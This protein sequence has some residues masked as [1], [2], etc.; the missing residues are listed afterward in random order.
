MGWTHAWGSVAIA[1]CIGAGCGGPPAPKTAISDKTPEE[2]IDHGPTTMEAEIGGMNEDA[3]DKAF[4]SLKI[5]DCVARGAERVNELGGQVKLKLRIDREGGV[6][7]AYLAESTL[8]DRDTEKCVI[9]LARART[10]PK[11]LGGE[12]LAEKVYAVDA[13]KAPAELDA[14]NVGGAVAR[15]RTDVQKCRGKVRGAFV[16]TVYVGR[17]GSVASAGVAV[18]SEDG[19]AVADC[20]V[21]ALRKLKFQRVPRTSKVSFEFK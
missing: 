6:K 17:D 15:A 11:P 1:A 5:M 9:D 16:A 12:G 13:P 21:E 10:W 19:E 20:V 18:P 4:S 7:W 3:M 2:K 8:G 14:R